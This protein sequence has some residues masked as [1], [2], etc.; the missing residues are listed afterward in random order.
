MDII[1][2]NFDSVRKALFQIFFG[3]D[4]SEDADNEKYKYIIPLQG[5]FENPIEADSNDTYIQYWIEEDSSLV[6][7]DYTFSEDGLTGYS[8]QKCVADILVRTVGKEAEGYAKLL[9]HLCKKEE[10]PEIWYNCCNA[11]KLIFTAPLQPN[12]ITWAGR[13]NSIAIDIR[14]KLYYD[15]LIPTTWEKLERID[16]TVHGEL[17][18]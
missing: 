5:N 8:R 16:F 4:G 17:T 13:N 10:T 2:V 15:E 11:E 3:I 18:P 1:G 12:K 9:R 6:Q 7:D 14:F